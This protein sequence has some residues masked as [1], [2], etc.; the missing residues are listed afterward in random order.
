MPSGVRSYLA[1]VLADFAMA[2]RSLE[3]LPMAAAIDWAEKLDL[4]DAFD[5]VATKDLKLKA[6]EL[7][8]LKKEAAGLLA[9]EV[10]P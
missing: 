4:A 10:K 6:R 2:D 3:D 5:K 1:W 8:R 7:K 9:Q